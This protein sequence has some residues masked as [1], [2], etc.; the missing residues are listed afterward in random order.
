M[1]RTRLNALASLTLMTL[2][3][4]SPGCSDDSSGTGDG[5]ETGDGSTGDGDGDPGDGDGDTGDGDG[6]TGPDFGD[7]GNGVV[8][9][10]EICDDGNNETEFP[11]Y[12]AT[13]CID[14]CSMVLA[15]CNDG[16]L[17]PGEDCDDGN[18]DSKDQ[19]TTSCTPNSM[20]VHAACTVF[21][22]GM[23]VEPFFNISQG[24]IQNCDNVELVTGAAVGCNRS[25]EY[26]GNNQVFAPGGDCQLISLMC[27]GDLCPPGPIG[28]YAAH[29]SCPAGHVLID[30]VIEGGGGI[31]TINSKVCLLAC[32]TDRECRWNEADTYWMGPGEFRCKTTPLSGGERV[33]NDPR[34]NML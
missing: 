25:W 24:E 22:E 23:E 13:D 16:A 20:G 28:D 34:N 29:T 32:E 12:A 27:D 26:I 17:D 19:C 31:P 5:S 9:M 33:C 2:T 8:D 11:P 18:A 14:D 1:R 10:G 7:C 15:T 3:L 30:K 21:E 6:D 4:S